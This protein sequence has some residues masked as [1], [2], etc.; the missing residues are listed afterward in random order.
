MGHAANFVVR[1]KLFSVRFCPSVKALHLVADF[2]NAKG[3]VNFDPVVLDS[4]SAKLLKS[5]EQAIGSGGSVV[6]LANN[7]LNNG[8]NNGDT[9]FN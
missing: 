6:H 7:L 4:K 9:P 8:V 2:S 5:C 3:R 1:D